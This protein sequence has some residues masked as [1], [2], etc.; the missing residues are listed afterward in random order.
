[1][2]VTG[3]DGLRLT[4]FVTTICCHLPDLELR[5]QHRAHCEDRI[6]TAKE[7]GPQNLPL[8]G[9]DQNRIW[10][11]IVEPVCELTAWTQLFAFEGHP[12]RRWEPEQP[13]L[14][15]FSIAGRITLHALRIHLRL[16][17]HAPQ[18]DLLTAGLRRLAAL[19]TPIRN[20]S[21]QH[22]GLEKD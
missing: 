7:F 16:S 21:G 10:R 6:R 5:R 20:R 22:A 9:S 3:H 19:P 12:D 17:T 4:A 2:R 8:H 11:A 18:V 13:R 15:T 14:Q 1:M